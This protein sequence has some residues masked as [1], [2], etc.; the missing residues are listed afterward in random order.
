MNGNLV[1]EVEERLVDKEGELDTVSVD[2]NKTRRKDT[3]L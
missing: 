3:Q 2:P 1:E